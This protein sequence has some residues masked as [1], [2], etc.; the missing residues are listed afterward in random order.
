MVDH[1]EEPDLV[2]DDD[3]LGDYYSDSPLSPQP[4]YP[5]LDNSFDSAIV[6][7]NVPRVPPE[8]VEKLMKVLRKIFGN[9]KIGTLATSDDGESFTGI[10]MPVDKETGNTCGFAF[11]QYTAPQEARKAVEVTQDYALDKRHV[12]Q[13]TLYSEAIKIRDAP[14]DFVP[15]SLAPYAERPDTTKWI[16]DPNQ[17]DSFVIRHGDDTTVLWNDGKNDPVVEYDGEREKQSGIN[18]CDYYCNWSPKGSFLATLIPAKGVILWGGENYEKLGRFPSQGVNFVLFSPQENFLLTSNMN[19]SDPAAI[20][21]FNVQTGKLLRNFPLYPNDFLTSEQQKEMKRGN[22]EMVPPPPP[23]QWSHDDK[24]LAR[25]G[26]DLISVY[27]TQTM[28]LLGSRSVVANGVAEFQFSPRDGIMSYWAPE[29]MNTP[30]QVTVVE[31]PSRKLLRQKNL[32]T[33][34]SFE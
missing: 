30:A 32:F 23:F 3:S 16:M 19:R 6:V 25:I 4:R 20:K 17:R 15:P 13:S 26:K 11:V 7:T 12:F 27:D 1:A 31:L 5:D 33:W 28:K 8:R 2:N 22:F 9:P 14:E 34:R 29:H 24:F 18:W 10:S 21:I